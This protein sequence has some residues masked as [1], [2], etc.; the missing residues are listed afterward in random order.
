MRRI[1]DAAR[2]AMYT[3]SQT[4]SSF[5]TPEMAP[6]VCPGP[7]SG[8]DRHKTGRSVHDAGLPAGPFAKHA[9]HGLGRLLPDSGVG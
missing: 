7:F 4:F 5:F 6:A 2:P 9:F 1:A 8:N 3:G